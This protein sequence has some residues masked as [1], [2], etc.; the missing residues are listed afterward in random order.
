MTSQFP[1]LPPKLAALMADAKA[2]LS[3]R[4]Q[5]EMDQQ[6]LIPPERITKQRDDEGFWI[7]A[8]S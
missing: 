5:Y 1:R 4:L 3:L 6:S 8:P 2:E 7:A